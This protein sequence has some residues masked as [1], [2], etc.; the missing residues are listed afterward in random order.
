MK[1]RENAL[2]IPTQRKYIKHLPNQTYRETKSIEKTVSLNPYSAPT[3]TTSSELPRPL[4]NNDRWQT[5]RDR[6]LTCAGVLYVMVLWFGLIAEHAQQ[7]KLVGY[8]E[9]LTPSDW[10]N[11][12]ADFSVASLQTKIIWPFTY[13][14]TAGALA[15]IALAAIRRIYHVSVPNAALWLYFLLLMLSGG[16]IGFLV[17]PL[18]LIEVVYDLIFSPYGSIESFDGE[19]LS[20]GIGQWMAVGFWAYSLLVLNLLGP[21][22][23]NK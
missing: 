14:A 8:N 22:R 3:A 11:A 1:G 20:D 19:A 2:S 10:W 7:M 16:F 18:G 6:G 17:L 23:R 9:P 4:D 21:Y 12:F 5:F 13:V 15:A